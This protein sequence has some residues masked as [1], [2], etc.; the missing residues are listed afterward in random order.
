MSMTA[1]GTGAAVT[2]SVI[3]VAAGAALTGSPLDDARTDGFELHSELP[4]NPHFD[5]P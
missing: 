5:Q 2:G 4:V 3:P 1:G